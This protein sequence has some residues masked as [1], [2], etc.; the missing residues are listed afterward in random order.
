MT[1]SISKLRDYFADKPAGSHAACQLFE[2]GHL[3]RLALN[4]DGGYD[5]DEIIYSPAGR[6]LEPLK[7]GSFEDCIRFIKSDICC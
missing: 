6:M 1:T 2:S 5:L 4:E 7:R 3:L